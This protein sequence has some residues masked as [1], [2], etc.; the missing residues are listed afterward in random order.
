MSDVLLAYIGF[1][2]GMTVGW[3]KFLPKIIKQKSVYKILNVISLF[4]MIVSYFPYK[5][6]IE[7]IP[8]GLALKYI[9]FLMICFVLVSFV[10]HFIVNCFKQTNGNH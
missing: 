9:V 8:N 6:F 1:T 3:L 10:M 5:N 2:I 4:F 7:N